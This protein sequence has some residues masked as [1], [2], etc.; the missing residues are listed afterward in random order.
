MTGR[1]P[2]GR[3][4]WAISSKVDALRQDLARR[5][6]AIPA[7]SSVATSAQAPPYC[8]R[9]T[10][11]EISQAIESA[12]DR[13][14][15]LSVV[16]FGHGLN[17]HRGTMLTVADTLAS[18]G[19]A[20]IAI[21]A[22]LHGIHPLTDATFGSLYIGNMPFGPGVNE[23]TFDVDYISNA[24]LA[25]GPD[26]IPDPSGIHLVNLT[27]LLTFRDNGRQ[28]IAD[29]SVLAVRYSHLCH[30]QPD[31]QLGLYLIFYTGLSSPL[32][33]YYYGKLSY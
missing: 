17:S 7:V 2:T 22:P 18:I 1:S 4:V 25:P 13:K 3:S 24:T 31:I 5:I 21:D 14:F 10:Q 15:S 6:A 26:G 27:S 20:V 33:Q 11:L 12:P 16:I 9:G 30:S 19:Y 29:V 28:A 23:R 32:W 8:C